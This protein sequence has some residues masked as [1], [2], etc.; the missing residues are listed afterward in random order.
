LK[1]LQVLAGHCSGTLA[2]IRAV[3]QLRESQARFEAFM[4]NTPAAAW[5]KDDSG[6]YIYANHSIQDLMQKPSRE[7]VAKTDNEIVPAEIAKQFRQEDAEVRQSGKPMRLEQ[8]L[9]SDPSHRWFVCKF[10]FISPRGT[11]F[12]GGLAFDITEHVAMRKSLVASEEKFQTLFDASPVA[13]ALLRDAKVEYANPSYRRMFNL[14]SGTPLNGRKF[15]DDIDE[16]CRGDLRDYLHQS[17]AVVSSLPPTEVKAIR[18]GGTEFPCIVQIAPVEVK[19]GKSHLVFLVDISDKRAL[20]A[21]LFQAQK[22]ESIGRLAGGIA[23]DFANLLTIIQGHAT[24]LERGSQNPGS[25]LDSIIRASQKA[26]ELT[27]HLLAFSRKQT[28]QIVETDLNIIVCELGRMLDRVI[29]EDITLRVHTEPLLPP[30]AADRTLLEQLITN[31]AVRARDAMHKG[32]RLTISTLFIPSG[33]SKKFTK[34]FS[35]GAVCLRI[36]DT[37]RVIPK[38]DLPQI[39]EPFYKSSIGTEASLRLATVYGIIKQHNGNIDVQSVAGQ[40]TRFDIYLPA[41]ASRPDQQAQL[42]LKRKPAGSILLVEDSA[43][44][45]G[46]VRDILSDEGFEVIEAPGY[47]AALEFFESARESIALVL[48]DVC[49]DDGSG[50]ELVEKI[51]SMKPDIK[52]ILT[53]GY[54]PHQL[55]AEIRLDANELFLPK[56]FQPEELLQLIEKLRLLE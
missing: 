2:R 43:D 28:L 5:I 19:E 13:I 4:E 23:H 39:F 33:D 45:R 3:D 24:R 52:A 16:D 25:S 12:V 54:D 32:G 10:P 27:R 18:S 1:L 44:L 42:E 34:G 22:M 30:V 15:L 21:Q 47:A 46:L 20:E 36:E 17:H 48:A 6:R 9:R 41:L 35:N 53:T 51:R 50:R 7:V 26:T 37:G 40:G 11:A 56:P 49:L 14:A 31:L 29:G 8:T 38:E 55:Q